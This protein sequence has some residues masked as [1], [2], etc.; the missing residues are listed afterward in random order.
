MEL[1]SIDLRKLIFNEKVKNFIKKKF[2]LKQKTNILIDVLEGLVALH[3]NDYAHC[4]LK[5]PNILLDDAFTAKITDFGITKSLKLGQT[6]K[7]SLKGVSERIS[8][9]EY[10]VEQKSNILIKSFD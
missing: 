2:S 6:N 7:T 1:M 4:D 8:S 9:Y 10:L 5:M 3:E